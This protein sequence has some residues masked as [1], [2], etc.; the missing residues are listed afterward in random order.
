MEYGLT[1]SVF[2]NDINEAINRVEALKFGETSINDKQFEPIPVDHA[3]CRKSSIGGADILPRILICEN[4]M[5]EAAL[6]VA[7]IGEVVSI[8]RLR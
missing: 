5:N 2:S 1:S 6:K 8:M 3:G 7:R 4:R